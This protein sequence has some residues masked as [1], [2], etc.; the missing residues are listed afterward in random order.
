M[1]KALQNS[2]FPFSFQIDK[3]K[4]ER[5]SL[6]IMKARSHSSTL[7]YQIWLIHSLKRERGHSGFLSHYH[8]LALGSKY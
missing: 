5:E 1:L 7:Y 2:N 4:N 8:G 6:P 3:E